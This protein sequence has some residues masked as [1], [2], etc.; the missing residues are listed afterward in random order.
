MPRQHRA[1][2]SHSFLRHYIGSS[3]GASP[4]WRAARRASVTLAAFALL[5]F[6]PSAVTAQEQ[7]PDSRIRAQGRLGTV[8][9]EVRAAAQA[10]DSYG[11][12]ISARDSS[13]GQPR[14]SAVSGPPASDRA[15]QTGFSGNRTGQPQN[16]TGRPASAVPGTAQPPAARVF[17]GPPG[18]GAPGWQRQDPPGITLPPEERPQGGPQPAGNVG[19]ATSRTS[20]RPA[21]EWV[22]VGDSSAMSLRVGELPYQGPLIVETTP[23]RLWAAREIPAGEPPVPGAEPQGAPGADP[24]ALPTATEPASG[25]SAGRVLEA[26]EVAVEVLEQIPLPDVRVRMNPNVGLVALPAWFWLEGFDGAAIA[27]SRTVDVPPLTDSSVPFDVVPAGDPSRQGTSFRVDVRVWPVRYVWT[28]GDGGAHVTQSFGRAYPQASDIQHVYQY[29]SLRF[30]NGYPVR[31]EAE[32]AAEF[33]VDGGPARPLPPVRR[34][35]DAEY[36]VQEIQAV[37]TRR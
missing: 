28:F 7:T 20:G 10:Q 25:T 4:P 11:V 8:Q 35:Y 9:V 14:G 13:A 33:R 2:R 24:A 1:I 6:E 12:E 5:L 37:L 22:P 18:D 15:P 32:F 21:L 31:A 19:D 36:R 17:L 3:V 27:R 23:G 26:R 29:S 30:R 16:G 34:R